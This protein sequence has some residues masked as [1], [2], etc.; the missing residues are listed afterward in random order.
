MLVLLWLRFS[1]NDPEL[2]VWSGGSQT[3]SV[4]PSA[5]QLDSA[6]V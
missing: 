2:L 5:Q 4:M 3:K 1:I 6:K